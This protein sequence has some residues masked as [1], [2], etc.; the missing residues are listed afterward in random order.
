MSIVGV[1]AWI[2]LFVCGAELLHTPGAVY[3]GALCIAVCGFTLGILV[4]RIP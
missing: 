2:V 4:S 1:F 3:G